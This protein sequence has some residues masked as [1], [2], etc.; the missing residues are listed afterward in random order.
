MTTLSPA[1]R[2]ETLLASDDPRANDIAQGLLCRG[3]PGRLWMMPKQAEMF[4]VLYAAGFTAKFRSDGWDW[5]SATGRRYSKG[6]AVMTA[7]EILASREKC[8]RE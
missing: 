7:R 6:N 8:L 2:G 4:S 1:P 5:Y 3:R